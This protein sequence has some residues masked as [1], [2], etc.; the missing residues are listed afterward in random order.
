MCKRYRY[1]YMY[2]ATHQGVGRRFDQSSSKTAQWGSTAGVP[3]ASASRTVKPYLQKKWRRCGVNRGCEWVKA[4][5][6]KGM[7]ALRWE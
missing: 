5:P 4:I 7:E 2:T 1:M 3:H 6:A